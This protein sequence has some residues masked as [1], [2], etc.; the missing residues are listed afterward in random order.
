MGTT[1][2]DFRQRDQFR[3]GVE[4]MRLDSFQCDRAAEVFLRFQRLSGLTDEVWCDQI[5]GAVPMS[6]LNR[7][8]HRGS[9][10]SIG[11]MEILAKST[12][13]ALGYCHEPIVRYIMQEGHPPPLV[14][15]LLA[16]QAVIKL[17]ANGLTDLQNRLCAAQRHT[18]VCREIRYFPS[19]EVLP[20]DVNEKFWSWRTRAFGKHVEHRARL[21]TDFT[22]NVRDRFVHR[23]GTC[24]ERLELYISRQQLVKLLFEIL[25]SAEFSNDER[26]EMVETWIA[27]SLHHRNIHFGVF[28]SERLTSNPDLHAYLGVHETIRV[29]DASYA[30]KRLVGPPGMFWFERT[31]GGAMIDKALAAIEVVR[32]AVPYDIDDKRQVER[33]LKRFLSPTSWYEVSSMN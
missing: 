4:I 7:L 30:Y 23:L 21:L 25:P 18:R 3:K 24:P 9:D 31:K 13:N 33:A 8:V 29:Y 32:Q 5:G 2:V 26:D 20:E 11:Q 27:H 6:T 16:A 15:E 19:P 17:T 1:T 10:F 14:E 22:G 12:A 28:E